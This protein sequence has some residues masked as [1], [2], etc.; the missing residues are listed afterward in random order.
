TLESQLRTR[1]LPTPG[2]TSS[3]M[4]TCGIDCLNANGT[5]GP[6]DQRNAVVFGGLENLGRDMAGLRGSIGAQIA[7]ADETLDLFCPCLSDGVPCSAENGPS[8]PAC[9]AEDP[10]YSDE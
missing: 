5:F 3:W 9:L 4:Y 6:Y 1:P 10:I 2:Y 7:E 8:Q